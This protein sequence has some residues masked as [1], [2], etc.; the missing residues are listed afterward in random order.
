MYVCVYISKYALTSFA[1]HLNKILMLIVVINR[2]K[3]TNEVATVAATTTSA[4]ASKAATT[5]ALWP[6]MQLMSN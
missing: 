6:A 5:T 2:F 3:N 4:R 1:C